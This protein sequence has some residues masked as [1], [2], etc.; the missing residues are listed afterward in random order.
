M[1]SKVEETGRFRAVWADG[2][3]E[4]VIEHTD[5]IDV[6]SL[7][8]TAREHLPGLKSYRAQ[9]G[10]TLNSD[11]EDWTDVQTGMALRRVH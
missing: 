1:V 6:T 11:G 7:S 9:S 3:P 2:R 8:S 10:R 5:F 4:I